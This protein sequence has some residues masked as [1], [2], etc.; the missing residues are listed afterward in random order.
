MIMLS[1]DV[2]I[3]TLSLVLKLTSVKT[4]FGIISPWLLPHL[5]IFEVVCIIITSSKYIRNIIN[6]QRYNH[7][8]TSTEL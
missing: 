4:D 5:V 2:E 6:T 7:G 8:Y 3:K 1:A